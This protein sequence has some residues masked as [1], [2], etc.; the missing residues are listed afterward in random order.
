MAGSG[1]LVVVGASGYLGAYVV[2]YAQSLGVEVVPVI[3]SEH[4]VSSVFRVQQ[5]PPLLCEDNGSSPCILKGRVVVI[6]A[7]PSAKR[8]EESDAI[9][10]TY[11][12]SLEQL[13]ER[14][15]FDRPSLVVYGSTIRVYGDETPLGVTESSSVFYGARYSRLRRSAEALLSAKLAAI[16]VP[17]MSLRL[18]NIIACPVVKHVGDFR[19]SVTYYLLSNWLAGRQPRLLNGSVTKS[20][21]AASELSRLLIKLANEVWPKL[22]PVANLGGYVFQIENWSQ[23]VRYAVRARHSQSYLLKSI[24]DYCEQMSQ[25]SLKCTPLENIGFIVNP[26]VSDELSKLVLNM[27]ITSYS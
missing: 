19:N 15:K 16:D 17:F 7:G 21:L 8:C 24:D 6:L 5:G 20:F 1:G 14:M 25:G 23:V 27:D 4:G 9:C 26:S 11:L 12:A 22:P 18:S 3:R 10:R 13:T 2:N